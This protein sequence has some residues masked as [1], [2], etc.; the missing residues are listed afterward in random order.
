MLFICADQHISDPRVD[1]L[2]RPFKSV[3]EMNDAII[4]RH[5]ELVSPTDEVWILG[6]I[7]YDLN[8][9]GLISKLNGRK[10]LIKGNHDTAPDTD[11][12]RYFEY[13]DTKGVLTT[14]HDGKKYEFFLVHKPI[15]H[16]PDYFNLSGHTHRTQ[17]ILRNALNVGLDNHHFLPLSLPK[18]IGFHH[19]ILHYYDANVWVG[20]TELHRETK[21]IL[22][23]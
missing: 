14:E 19:A 15:E 11:Y 8:D 6:D 9:I 4:A 5:N 23:G 18:V 1:L 17:M 20:N 2:G 10:N 3:K 16:S 21:P 7:V 13:V 22:K 12:Y